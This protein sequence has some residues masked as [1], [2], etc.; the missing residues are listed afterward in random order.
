V[1]HNTGL[2]LRKWSYV[3][4][5]VDSNFFMPVTVNTLAYYYYYIII[6]IVIIMGRTLLHTDFVYIK[7]VG[8]NLKV[9]YRR[10]TYNC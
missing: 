6:I 4:I 5:I 2:V 8:H 1:G 3:R 7:S 9:S 10:H